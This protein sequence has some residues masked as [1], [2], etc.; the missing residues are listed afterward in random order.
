MV[1]LV[2]AAHKVEEPGLTG[3]LIPEVDYTYIDIVV[4]VF[5]RDY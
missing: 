1:K 2:C 5:L 4:L 3:N